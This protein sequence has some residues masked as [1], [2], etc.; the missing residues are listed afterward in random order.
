MTSSPYT[1]ATCDHCGEPLPPGSTFCEKCGTRV[2]NP[3]AAG[4]V[5]AT[6]P[7]SWPSASQPYPGQS[8]ALGGSF[9]GASSQDTRLPDGLLVGS[10]SPNETYLGNR[11][12][13]TD[14]GTNFDPLENPNYQRALLAQFM[15]TVAAW[16]IGSVV[17]FLVFGIA[18]L[19]QQLRLMQENAFGSLQ[20]GGGVPTSPLLVIWQILWAA[21]SLVLACLFWLRKLTVQLSEW[22]LTVDG[23]G[24]AAGPALDHMYTIIAARG[25]PIG[26]MN[27]VRLSPS[28]QQARAYLQVDDDVF[29]GFVSCFPFGADLF[30]GWTFW[31]NM[32][33]GRWLLM[34]LRRLIG[35]GGGIYTAL[36]YDQP[37][38]LREVLHSAVRQGVDI[39]AGNAEP[40]GQGT[41]GYHVPLTT[42]TL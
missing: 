39:A 12:G 34:T 25:T 35:R 19:G 30:I 27:V 8:G 13:Y 38:A 24:R 26:H 29:T 31:L 20:G 15:G 14:A 22:M 37:K 41:I 18:G 21:W 36:A 4:E 9:P 3:G 2:K 5:E 7:S 42:V 16:A 32:S 28:R 11:L 1:P 17:L 23:Q 6:A 33:P 10:A 40:Q